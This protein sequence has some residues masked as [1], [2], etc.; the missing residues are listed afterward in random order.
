MGLFSY[1][2]TRLS[3]PSVTGQFPGTA[4][5]LIAPITNWMRP[6][7]TS[8]VRW[9]TDQNKIGQSTLTTNDRFYITPEPTITSDALEY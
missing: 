7:L 2:I 1:L 3:T 8:R 9:P 6:S 5:M 4:T